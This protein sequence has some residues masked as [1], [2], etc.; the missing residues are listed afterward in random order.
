MNC[1]GCCLPESMLLGS[2]FSSQPKY[3]KN[4]KTKTKTQDLHVRADYL[5]KWL[6]DAVPQS[7]VANTLSGRLV[8]VWSPD[9]DTLQAHCTHPDV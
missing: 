4:K 8:V 9:C 2:N 5:P 1:S 6:V 7:N 3:G